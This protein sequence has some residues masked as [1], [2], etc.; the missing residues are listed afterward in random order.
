LT[1]AGSQ[2]RF[3]VIAE[4]VLRSLLADVQVD[5]DIDAA[6]QHVLSGMSELGVHP[7]VPDG[8]A[9]YDWVARDW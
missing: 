7:D 5:R 3:A 1:A 8:S 2:K 6:V 4:G 9:G